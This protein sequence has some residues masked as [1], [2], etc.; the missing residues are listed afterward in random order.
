MRTSS[1]T[2]SGGHYLVLVSVH[3]LIRGR[4]PE[5]GRDAD[6]GGQVK[7]VLELARALA[8]DPAIGRVDLLT[9]RIE[10]PKVSPDYAV[11]E[12]QIAPGAY[13]VRI[14]CGPRRYFRKEVLWRYLDS[15]VDEALLHIRRVGRL[16]LVVHGHYADGGY[17]GS[18]LA[19]LLG[20]PFVFT[21]HSLGRVKRAYLRERGVSEKRLESYYHIS[22]RIEAEE[23]ALDAAARVIASTRHE[24]EEQYARYD[25][26]HPDRKLVIPPGTDLERFKPPAPGMEPPPIRAELARFLREPD[27]PLVLA[28]ARPDERKNLATLVEAFGRHPRLRDRANLV[29]IAGNRDDIREMDRRPRRVLNELLLLIDAHDLYGHVAFPK[30]HTPEDIPDLYRLAAHSRGVFVLPTIHELFGLTLIEAAASGLPLVAAHNGGPPEIVDYCENGLLVDPQDADAMGRA[31]EE[32]LDDPERWETW[33]RR[34]IR[35]ARERYSWKAHVRTYLEAVRAM[36]QEDEYRPSPVFFKSRLPR[37]DRMLVSDIDNTMTGD[38]EG[39]RLLV[40]R[41]AAAQG[42]VGFGVA[43]GRT[44]EGAVS[45]L[46]R[47]EVPLPDVMITSVGTEIYYG[48]YRVSDAVD[49]PHDRNWAKHISY[50]WERE[51]LQEALAGVPGLT[52][53][54][55]EAQR[56]FKLSYFVDEEAAPSIEALRSLLRQQGLSANLIYSHG[57]FLDVIPIRASKGRAIRYVA[58]RWGVPIERF[59]VAGDSGNDEEMLRGNTLAVVVGNHSPELEHLRDDPRIYFATAHH[60]RGILEGIDHYDFFGE[61][62][63]PVHQ[64]A[65]A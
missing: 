54:P 31:I 52:L 2:S 25:H 20:V 1:S 44:V 37:I 7:Y 12:E 16:P 27:R 53:Q 17:V 3:G 55:G 62:R 4:D 61:I 47:Y 32:V 39:L 51:A 6:T 60:A 21:G 9:R 40:E 59:L 30:H 28:I 45:V 35:R 41:L 13:I 43:T 49:W 11:P 65:G 63:Y 22:T 50:R 5:L 33:S 48:P 24:I 36:M 58:M 38:D 64:A 15:F 57:Q 34:G 14:P 26:F 8:A 18:R 29:L 19:G 56:P 46:R 23:E 10:D 42:T